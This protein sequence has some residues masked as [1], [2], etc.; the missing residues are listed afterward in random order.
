M[1]SLQL[2]IFADEATTAHFEAVDAALQQ[3]AGGI[4]AHK[5]LLLTRF[6]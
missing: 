1:T 2:Q 3:F 4:A 5:K 6:G